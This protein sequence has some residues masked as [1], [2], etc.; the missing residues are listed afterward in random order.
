MPVR[1]VILDVK[2]QALGRVARDIIIQHYNVTDQWR[3]IPRLP[4]LAAYVVVP[5]LFSLHHPQSLMVL[6]LS[7]F[8]NMASLLTITTTLSKYRIIAFSFHE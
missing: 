2:T 7:F 8:L 1:V 3:V 6:S 5:V 4:L